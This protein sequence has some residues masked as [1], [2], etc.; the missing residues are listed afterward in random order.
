MNIGQKDVELAQR[1]PLGMNV[2][3]YV[4]LKIGRSNQRSPMR[5]FK[6]C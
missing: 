6:V 3:R 5:P 2:Y 4:A 1:K